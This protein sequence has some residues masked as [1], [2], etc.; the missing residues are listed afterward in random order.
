M[1]A[2]VGSIDQ[3]S[4]SSS[5]R[6]IRWW[7]PIT[8]VL[9]CL[10]ALSFDVSTSR[11]FEDKQLPPVVDRN[12]REALE[13][14]EVFGH[15][16]GAMLIVIAV[17]VLDPGK[18]RLWPWMF[19]GSLGAGI[20][21]NALKYCMPRTRP[22][23]FQLAAGTVWDTFVKGSHTGWGMHSFPS[24]HTATAVGLA[25]VLSDRYPRGRW[26]FAMLAV[27]AGL[28]RIVSLAHFP[29]DVCAGALVGWLV[30]TICVASMPAESNKI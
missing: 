17:L 9:C 19:A 4:W 3:K 20:A 25:V 29:S 24:A 5:F 21:A 14:C 1:D 12:L 22:R 26:Y 16:F 11:I 13:I 18:R 6:K 28:Q 2:V 15:G 30:G 8:L 27:L 23:D 7:L 10:A